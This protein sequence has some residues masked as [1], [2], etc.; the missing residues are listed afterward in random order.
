MTIIPYNIS[1]LLS[2]A[3]L[4]VTVPP[5]AVYALRLYL[6]SAV[7]LFGG[8]EPSHPRMHHYNPMVS[9]IIPVFNRADIVDRLM[10]RVTSFTYTDYEVLVVDDSH[11]STPEKLE[12]WRADPRVMA[13]YRPA[14]NGWKAGALNAALKMVS[15]RSE[16]CLFLDADSMPEPD[17]LGRFVERM[18]ETRADVV[19]GA[20]EPDENVSKSWV[21]RG[22][23]LVLNGYNFVDIQAR[24]ELGLLIPI[25]GSNFMARSELIKSNPFQETAAEDWELTAELW[26]KGWKVVYA[27]DIVVRGESPAHLRGVLRRYSLWAESTT[28]DTIHMAAS[29]YGSRNIRRRVKLDF[30]LSGFSYLMSV[31]VILAAAGFLLVPYPFLQGTAAPVAF[32]SS[33]LA[34]VMLP[35]APLSMLAVTYVH[36]TERRLLSVLLALAGSVL[37]LPVVAYSSLKGVFKHGRPLKV[38]ADAGWVDVDAIEAEMQG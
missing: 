5:L 7:S 1:L 10:A 12:A 22:V 4:I 33:V 25:T 15:P 29:I 21:S 30:F 11:D 37:V 28:A 18:E 17:L 27:P 8:R 19:Q 2:Q 14:R 36:G 16:F 9:I 13:I 23:A 35:A 20:Q 26:S 6:F 24:K 38:K 32:W 34:L 3:L 31:F